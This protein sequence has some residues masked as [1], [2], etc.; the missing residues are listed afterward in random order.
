MK[1]FSEVINARDWENQHVTDQH[2]AQAHAPLRAY[3]SQQA[4]L[5]NQDSNYQQS[6]NGEWAFQLFAK[7]EN[8]PADCISTDFDDKS[9]PSIPVPGNWQLQGHD[10]PIYTNVKYPFADTPPFVPQ[11][12][13][14]GVY[15]LQ[16]DLP[17][18]WEGRKHSIIFDGV[19]SAFHLWCNGVWIGYSQ[20][21]RLAAEFDLTEHLLAENNQLTVMVMRWS[22]GSYL[23]DQDMWWLS[24]IFRDVTLLSKP[25]FSI[26]D[27]AI[28]TDL[29]RCYNHGTLNVSTF[30][31]EQSQEYQ[32]QV[33]LFDAQLQPVTEVVSAN[34]G[35]RI[36]DEKGACLDLVEHQ[37]SIASPQKWSAESP[38]LYRAVVSLVD[39]DGKEIDCE[40]YQ[41]GFRVVEISDG[42]TCDHFFAIC[43]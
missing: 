36:I 41:V 25:L 9:W 33:Q 32:V 20:D 31:S 14:T 3:H 16:F 13:P 15:R 8:V 1:T 22:D 38:Y 24:G 11:D 28:T 18:S 29:D 21:S 10:K 6:L 19:N 12:N 7:P 30:L 17:E 37:I 43:G 2:V 23:E 35:Q 40:A 39:S 34:S 4:A 26:R 42:P 27:V 5:N